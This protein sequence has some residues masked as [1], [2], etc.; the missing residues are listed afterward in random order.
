[1]TEKH[2]CANYMKMDKCF[3]QVLTKL[4]LLPDV[5]T[6]VE[7]CIDHVICDQPSKLCFTRKCVNCVNKMT[8]ID[9]INDNIDINM[10]CKWTQWETVQE[11]RVIRGKQVMLERTI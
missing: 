7:S 6:R 11:K 10:A 8:T 3:I 2:V 4:K 9:V 1:M 5:C